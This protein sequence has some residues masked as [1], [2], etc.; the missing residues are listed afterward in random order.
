MT[1]PL[2]ARPG[3][4]IACSV[5]GFGGTAIYAAQLLTGAGKWARYCHTKIYVGGGMVVQAEPGGATHVPYE[6]TSLE[7][8]S[9]AQWMLNGFQRAAFVKA[10]LSQV[11]HGYAPLE[12]PYLVA[13]QLHIP[14]PGLQKEIMDSG[15]MI[16]SQLADWTWQQGG[17][18]VHIFNDGRW[19]GD[20]MPWQLAQAF[21]DGPGRQ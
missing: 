1:V 3:D 9:S 19:P 21:A 5:G 16:C 11:G 17:Q 8:W 7:I 18:P 14:V 13:H 15:S 4:L 10:A 2:N 6:P 12:Y 20:V